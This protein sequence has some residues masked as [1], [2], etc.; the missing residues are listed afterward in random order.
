MWLDMADIDSAFSQIS[1]SL[2]V[3]LTIA[4]GRE[5]LENGSL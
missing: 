3:M 2:S 5:F 1:V 4:D